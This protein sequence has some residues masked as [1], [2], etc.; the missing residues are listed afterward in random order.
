VIKEPWK[1][2][3]QAASISLL[4]V[5]GA[6]GIDYQARP[7]VYTPIKSAVVLGDAERLTN[8]CLGYIKRH[9]VLAGN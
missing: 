8:I 4:M 1:G 6:A 3:L 5:I 9:E 2:A 7:E